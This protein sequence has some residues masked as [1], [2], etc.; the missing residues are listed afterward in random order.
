MNTISNY[1]YID[2]IFMKLL[3]R[4]ITV[5]DISNI[6]NEE[7]TETDKKILSFV[8]NIYPNNI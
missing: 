8:N 5:K 2:N 7:I 3:K 4:W 1:D 6:N